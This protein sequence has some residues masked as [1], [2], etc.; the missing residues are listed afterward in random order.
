ML[1]IHDYEC[2][3]CDVRW[4]QLVEEHEVVGCGRCGDEAKKIMSAP[5]IHTLE[6]HM[7]GYRG[8]GAEDAYTPAHGFRDPN[9]TDEHGKPVV[10][11]SL[12]EKNALLKKHGLEIKDSSRDWTKQKRSKRPMRFTKE[13]RKTSQLGVN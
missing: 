6:T 12:K 8:D 2:E 7:R 4:E 1:K 9:L 3:H 5:A 13:G 11:S 10:Y